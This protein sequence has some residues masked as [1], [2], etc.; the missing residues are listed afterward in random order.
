MDGVGQILAFTTGG[1][2]NLGLAEGELKVREVEK[3][4]KVSCMNTDAEWPGEEGKEGQTACGTSQQVAQ[5]PFGSL[6][7]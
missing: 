6:H 2:F 3:K 4:A 1:W 5:P 7:L